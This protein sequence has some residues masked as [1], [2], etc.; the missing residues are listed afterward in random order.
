MLEYW[1]RE[2]EWEVNSIP[3]LYVFGLVFRMGIGIKKLISMKIKSHS[4]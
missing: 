2:W 3:I 4:Q 1:N